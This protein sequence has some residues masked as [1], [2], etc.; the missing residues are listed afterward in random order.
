MFF[1]FEKLSERERGKK[2]K[3]LIDLHLINLYSPCIISQQE[4]QM[5]NKQHTHTQC[6]HTR[7]RKDP[8]KFLDIRILFAE[9]TLNIS[10][11]EILENELRYILI[12]REKVKYLIFY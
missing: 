9:F 4:I 8:K 1:N 7:I 5:S 10:T 6:T 12:Q 11:T 3:K 2:K